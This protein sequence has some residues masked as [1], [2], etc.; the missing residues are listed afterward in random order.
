VR[1][2]EPDGIFD[3]LNWGAILLG[4]LVDF[5]LTMVAA[6]PLMLWFAG[7]AAFSEDEAASERAIDQAT[8]SPEFLLTFLVVGLAA[9]AYGGYVGARRAGAH[10]LRHGGWVAVASALLA[11]LSMLLPGTTETSPSPVW[12]EALALGLMLPA[13]VFGGFLAMRRSGPPG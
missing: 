8:Q 3:G 11:F 1:P 7:P 2:I 6:L 13:G 9:T 12:Y 10:H 5:A 4:A